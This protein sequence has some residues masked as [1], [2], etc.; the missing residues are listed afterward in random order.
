MLHTFKMI[1]KID[2][3]LVSFSVLKKKHLFYELKE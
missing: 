3:N 1:S 2:L